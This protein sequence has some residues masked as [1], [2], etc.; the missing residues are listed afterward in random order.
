[1]RTPAPAHASTRSRLS[2]IGETLLEMRDD[3]EPALA[4]GAPDVGGGADEEEVGTLAG[5]ASPKAEIAQRLA[6][7]LVDRNRRANRSDA[8][9]DI[10]VKVVARLN[11]RAHP[12]ITM[13]SR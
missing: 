5:Q 1:M 2:S 10:A 11:Q 12:S 8:S 9:G 6:R 13:A 4:L 7:V 3:A